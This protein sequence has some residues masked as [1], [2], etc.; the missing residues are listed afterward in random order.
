METKPQTQ[1]RGLTRK[2]DGRKCRSS[3]G[4]IASL[5][6]AVKARLPFA[7]RRSD[8]LGCRGILERIIRLEIEE[9]ADLDID[10]FY[11]GKPLPLRQIVNHCTPETSIMLYVNYISIF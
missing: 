6:Y 8:F 7:G 11:C 5:L 3:L 1:R 4:L 10:W 2:G 9:E